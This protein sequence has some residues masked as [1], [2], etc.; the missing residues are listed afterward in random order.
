MLLE[1]GFDIP[2]VLRRQ[3]ETCPPGVLGRIAGRPGRHL[4]FAQRIGHM[5][6]EDLPLRHV[7]HLH[8][9]Q[10]HVMPGPPRQPSA[11]GRTFH[12]RAFDHTMEILPANNAAAGHETLHF[13]SD[14]SGQRHR[15]VL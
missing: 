4:R 8:L 12:S 9:D 13:V 5:D 11:Y 7:S 2:V 14:L 1:D 15:G 6:L 3:V 10:D